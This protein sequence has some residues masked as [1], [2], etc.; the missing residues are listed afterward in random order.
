M[1][2]SG[3]SD[4]EQ[5]VDNVSYMQDIMP[6]NNEEREIIEKATE[7]I[8]SNIAITCTSCQYCVDDCP[9]GLLYELNPG[10]GQKSF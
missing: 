9:C 5:V 6:S 10:L 7:I 4:Y 8:N 3:I 2:L 1:V